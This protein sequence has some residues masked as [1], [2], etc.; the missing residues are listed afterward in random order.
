[1]IAANCAATSDGS[2][3]AASRPARSLILIALTSESVRT[4]RVV[5]SHTISGTETRGSSAKYW[6]KRSALAASWR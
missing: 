3:P 2:M 4:R 1:M 5:R 6:A